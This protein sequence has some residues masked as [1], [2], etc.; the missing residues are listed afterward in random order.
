MQ[1]T[2][3]DGRGP[4]RGCDLVQHVQPSRQPRPDRRQQR[5]DEQ[6]EVGRDLFGEQGSAAGAV[7]ARALPASAVP[8]GRRHGQVGTFNEGKV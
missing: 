7:S 5:R 2:G 4:E 6:P 3:A 8:G 1:R